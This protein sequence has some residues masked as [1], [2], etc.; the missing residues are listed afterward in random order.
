MTAGS[1]KAAFQV[2][3]DGKDITDRVSPR[4]LS[5]TLTEARGD[6]A[7]Q[8][9]L[10]IDDAD[11]KMAIPKRGAELAVSLG[12]AGQ[13]LVGKGKF[14]VDDVEH[15]G[16]PDTITLRARSADF[17]S[18]LRL[19]RERSWTDTTAGQV[20]ADIA[21]RHGLTLKVSD[22]LA[23]QELPILA[24][25]RE[26][27]LQVLRKLGKQFDAVATIK[28]GMLLFAP[29]GAGKTASG[30][31]LP[32]FRVRRQDGDRHSW[33]AADRDGAYTGVTASWRSSAG[34]KRHSERAGKTGKVKHLRRVYS[35]KVD[36]Q[37]AAKAEWARVQRGGAT[38]S[39]NL[40]LGRPDLF[41]ELQGAVSGF[42]KP[43]FDHGSWLIVRT[44]HTLAAG[45]LVTA[46]ELETAIG[47][48]AA[49]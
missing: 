40:A 13:A 38:L 1:H 44:V 7:D 6:E 23:G 36:A 19:R 15:S 49:A 8:L 11:G 43:E 25:S 46:L 37:R 21:G 33:K 24:Q 32:P 47:G 22:N 14:K 4:L 3:L 20:L 12:W 45:G 17:T 27:D 18:D 48:A 10:V 9:D 5:L 2:L 35:T 41:P 29:I 16:A 28:S 34:A 31:D 26:S 30:K 42:G 39:L